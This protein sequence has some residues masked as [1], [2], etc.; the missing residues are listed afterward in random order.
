MEK[1][2][3]R[4]IRRSTFAER[5]KPGVCKWVGVHLASETGLTQ[6]KYWLYVSQNEP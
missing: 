5:L 4:R 3:A 6:T 2:T 1:D